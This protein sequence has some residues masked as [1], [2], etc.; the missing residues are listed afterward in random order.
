MIAI[1][2]GKR[3]PFVVRKSNVRDGALRLVG[4]C[5][6]DCLMNGEGISLFGA[7]ERAFRLY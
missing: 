5:Y 1:F 3:V 2:K 4:D 7:V 6:I